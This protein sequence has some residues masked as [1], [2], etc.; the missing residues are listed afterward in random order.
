M[1]RG[2][3]PKLLT[4]F[5][6]ERGYM[7]E[8][9]G[10]VH[11][12]IHY[13]GH[14]FDRPA[15]DAAARILTRILEPESPRGREPGDIVDIDLLQRGKSLRLRIVANDRPVGLGT[16]AQERTEDGDGDGDSQA[17]DR[18]RRTVEGHYAQP[19]SCKPN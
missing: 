15:A 6:I 3:L 7:T 9:P 17:S 16:R 13:Q 14:R 12:A 2:I 4:C 8:W 11:T 1:S 19:I 18:Y 5:R 10:Y